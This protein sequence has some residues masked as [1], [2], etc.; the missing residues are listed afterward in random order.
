MNYQESTVHGH[1]PVLLW[2]VDCGLWT[3]KNYLQKIKKAYYICTF[4]NEPGNNHTIYPQH[5]S[6]YLLPLYAV[7]HHIFHINPLKAL[8]ILL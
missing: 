5:S 4:I 1:D 2:T 7:R 6:L 3:L 8:P